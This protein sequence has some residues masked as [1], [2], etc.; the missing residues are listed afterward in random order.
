[1]T[2]PK[3]IAILSVP[4]DLGAGRQGASG[5]PAAVWNAG[6]ES[7]LRALGIA[8]ENAGIVRA[9]VPDST[10]STDSTDET[11]ST[12]EAIPSS[13]KLKHLAEVV[14]VNES[15]AA[16][17]SRVVEAGRFPLVIGGDHSIAIG[18]IAGIAPHYRNLGVIWIDAHSDLN[19]PEST[20]SGNIHG[21][22]LRVS[23]GEGDERLTRIG[24]EAAK[25]KPE[26]VVLIGARSLDP[27]EKAYIKS[28]NITCFTMHDVDRRGMSQVIE[29]AIRIA[30]AGT[31][32]VHL[33]FD[34]DSVDPGVAPGT[35]TPVQGGLSYREAHLA[36]E[37][38]NESGIVTSAEFVEL[39]P[40]LDAGSKTTE[41]TLELIG[42]LLGERIL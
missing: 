16:R 32:G 27:G 17:V 2:A 19:T 12:N 6:L 33:S 21:M 40:A 23:L 31:D 29:E 34:I 10:D 41:L 14:A 37:M 36:L 22:S 7:R 9:D 25:I 30:G 8:F 3:E 24:G 35:G 13:P 39:S 38:L 42:S 11:G 1:M 4:F 26:N 20:E 15:L 28:R 18:S 5:G